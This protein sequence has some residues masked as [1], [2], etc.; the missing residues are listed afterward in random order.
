[1][2][3]APLFASLPK[4]QRNYFP[5]H[6]LII[7]VRSLLN[8]LRENVFNLLATQACCYNDTIG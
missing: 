3:K 5:L 8:M 7:G 1:M 2:Q 4:M 6:F